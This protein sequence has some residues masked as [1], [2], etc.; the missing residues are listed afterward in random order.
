MMRRW[1][2]V[3]VFLFFGSI[4]IAYSQ[5]MP[6]GIS[7]QAV[8]RNATGDELINQTVTV[9]LSLLKGSPSGDPDWIE[10]HTVKTDA[11]GLFNLIIGEGSREGG[12]S[13]AFS[14]IQWGKEPHF[15]KIE[16][17]FGFGFR[18]MGTN[19]FLAVPYALFALNSG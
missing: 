10:S 8:A 17:D 15:L 5:Q 7:Y 3:L 12:A 19:P 18:N 16:V 11:Y 9:R 1:I 6:S 2:F 13:A 14:D 4:R